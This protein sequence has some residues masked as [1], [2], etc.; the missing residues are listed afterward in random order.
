MYNKDTRI[1]RNQEYYQRSTFLYEHEPFTLNYAMQSTLIAC[2]YIVSACVACNILIFLLTV[3][4]CDD[5]VVMRRFLVHCLTGC[6]N[7][8]KCT[9]CHV[10]PQHQQRHSVCYAPHAEKK[11]YIYCTFQ[12]AALYG[13][14]YTIEYIDYRIYDDNGHCK[15]RR[16]DAFIKCIVRRCFVVTKGQ[17]EQMG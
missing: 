6:E 8:H 12:G 17:K 11:T 1:H 3:I 2:C 7:W 16:C 4:L 15:S 9:I 14:I 13:D 5:E 10:L